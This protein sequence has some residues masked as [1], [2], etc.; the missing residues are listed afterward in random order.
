MTR[1][2]RSLVVA[3][4]VVV[5]VAAC[6]EVTPT[7]P[8]AA[9][10]AAAAA[11]DLVTA[12]APLPTGSCTVAPNGASYDVTVSWSGISP[13][14]IELWQTNGTQAIVQTVL[15]H[16]PKKGSITYTVATAPD[17]ALIEGS[18][19]GMKVLCTAA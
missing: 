7:A 3:G 16:S 10:P 9:V 15:S 19:I 1:S 12:A 4:V 14:R 18:Q 8:R 6:S 13:R 17:Y 11:G 2:L 5:T